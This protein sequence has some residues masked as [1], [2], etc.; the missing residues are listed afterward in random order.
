VLARRRL[1]KTGKESLPR[2][3]IIHLIEIIFAFL[4]FSLFLNLSS[5]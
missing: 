2:N 1:Q 5:F 3:I 4:A